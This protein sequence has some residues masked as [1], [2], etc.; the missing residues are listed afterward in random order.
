MRDSSTAGMKTFT[1][2]LAA[3]PTLQVRAAKPRLEVDADTLVQLDKDSLT[4]TRTLNLRTDRP[5]HELRITL[6]EGEEFI[7]IDSA[8]KDF[9]WKRVARVIEMRFPAGVTLAA[10]VLVNLHTR[11]K[12]LKAWSGPRIPELVKVQPLSIPEA[13]KIAGYSAL[14]FDDS[15]RVAL[16]DTSGLEDRDAKLAPV[17]GRMAWFG[18]RDW[19]LG[20][21]VERAEPPSPPRSPRMPC[22]APARSRSKARSRSTSAVLPCAPF[23]SNCPLL[24][25]NSSA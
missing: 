22:H 16:K 9:E 6:P 17:K 10:P 8:A 14:S 23:S 25:P 15:W 12:L 18:L 19:A 7:R 11:Q 13:V 1:A 5:V 3:L 2:S 24:K 21:E 20:F 4:L